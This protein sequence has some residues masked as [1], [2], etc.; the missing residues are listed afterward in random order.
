[1]KS[2]G[3]LSQTPELQDRLRLLQEAAVGKLDALLCPR[4]HEP[5]VSVWFTHPAANEYQTW[6]LC[7]KCGLEMRAQNTGRP[8]FYSKERDLIAR[9]STKRTPVLTTHH[10]S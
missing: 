8:A 5:A 1:M 9:D 7:A 2:D 6:F 3:S 10:R 4:C